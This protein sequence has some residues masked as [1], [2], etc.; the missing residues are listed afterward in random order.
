[1]SIFEQIMELEAKKQ[2][3]LDQA[4]REALTRAEKAV[5]ELNDLGFH[6]ELVERSTPT[7]TQNTTRRAGVSEQVLEVV[8][9]APAGL[10]RADVLTQLNAESSSEKH[11]VSNALANLKKKG[12]LTNT[13]GLYKVTD[14]HTTS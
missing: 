13:D 12:K 11:S 7:K 4:K 10:T 6:Y 1:M 8:K 3:L 5:S 14:N 9:S 2:S